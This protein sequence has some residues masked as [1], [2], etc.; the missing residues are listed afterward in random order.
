LEATKKTGNKINTKKTLEDK[1]FTITNKE[2]DVIEEKELSS[3]KCPFCGS[4]LQAGEIV[5]HLCG[6][7]TTNV[8]EDNSENNFAFKVE[9]KS[10]SVIVLIIIIIIAL[11]SLYIFFPMLRYTIRDAKIVEV[12]EVIVEEKEKNEL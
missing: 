11:L 10:R 6:S 7:N 5:C 3:R 8:V 4:H 9:K 12:N 2:N 1:G